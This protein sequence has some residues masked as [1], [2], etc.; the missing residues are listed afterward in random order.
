[1]RVSAIKIAATDT[2][3]TPYLKKIANSGLPTIL[4]TGM[5]SLAEIEQAVNILQKNGLN[6]KI[7]LLQCTSEYPAPFEDINL[8]AITTL[9][10][11]F[12]CPVGF[13]DHTNGIGASP[14][15]VACGA[16]I[17]EKHFTLDKTMRGPDHRASIEPNELMELVKIIRNVELSLGDGIKKVMPSELKNK[18]LMQKSLVA[19]KNIKTGQIIREDDITCK[20][21]GIG[22]QPYWYDQILHKRAK[23]NILKNTLIT[24]DKIEW[25]D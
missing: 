2:N 12:G 8:R 22:L 5:S 13:S 1:M 24:L 25:V 23:G 7:S 15:A 16:C 3:N 4:S 19:K 6:N 14:W 18:P 10:H 21:P 11:A 17:I 20:R 9:Q